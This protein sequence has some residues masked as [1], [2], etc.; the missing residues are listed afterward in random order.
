MDFASMDPQTAKVAIQLQLA[1][2]AELLDSLYND[3]EISEGDERT[4]LQTLQSELT[5]QLALLEGQVL[6]VKILKDE[7][8]ERVAFKKL[9]DD[10]RQA[11]TDHQLAMRL[12]GMP[13]G[14]AD[15][16]FSADYEAQLRE[17]EENDQDEQWEMAKDLYASAVETA[18]GDTIQG[19]L[20]GGP[21]QPAVADRAPLHGVR[22]GPS[23]QTKGD[24]RP[25]ILGSDAFIK[26]NA[27]M[28][29]VPTKNALRLQ[30]AP[31]PHTY[32]R[33][34][35]L[36]L[37][38]SAITNPTLFPPR[39]CKVAI[40][41]DTC[42]AT[43]PRELIKE[44]DL[45]V[46]ELATPNPTYCAN[47]DCSKFVQP[48]DITSGVGNCVFCK[49]KTCVQFKSQEHSGLCPSDPHVQLLMDAAKRSK[50]QQCTRYSNMVEL[51]QGCF[52]M[53]YVFTS[54]EHSGLTTTAVDA[55]IN[56]A[57]SVA[58]SGSVAIA[59]SGTKTI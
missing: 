15:T 5:H 49:K 31:E 28:E 13:V 40:P 45:K 59:P 10:E 54:N 29:I 41:L 39:C 25:K 46:E 38:T 23:K 36:D 43:L 55:A 34:C 57:T 42:R 32:C 58:Y 19:A 47:A 7:Y 33:T 35:L 48:K 52:H 53:T 56:F 14:P 17:A 1:D 8:N 44:F 9:L 6:V 22:T 11:I 16:A 30:C 4:S 50:W 2:I 37:F 27:C 12:A 20:E 24:A 51:A 21:V 18:E 3:N 26:C